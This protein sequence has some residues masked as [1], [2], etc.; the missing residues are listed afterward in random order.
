MQLISVMDRRISVTFYL[1]PGLW[2]RIT[3]T[4]CSARELAVFCCTFFRVQIEFHHI[5]CPCWESYIW[6]VLVKCTFL[7]DL[8]LSVKSEEMFDWRRKQIAGHWSRDFTCHFTMVC[9]QLLLIACSLSSIVYG[10]HN[11]QVRRKSKG[12]FFLVLTDSNLNRKQTVS[13]T[14]QYRGQNEIYDSMSKTEN[15]WQVAFSLSNI[16]HNVC[17]CHF[18]LTDEKIAM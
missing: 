2:Y 3:Q 10:Q 1:V 13:L 15:K 11:Y 4:P 12:D 14:V 18:N 7:F 9:S 8:V 5:V 6:V 16:L 17:S